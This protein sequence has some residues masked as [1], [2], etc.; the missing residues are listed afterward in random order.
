MAGMRSSRPARSVIPEP[1]ASGRGRRNGHSHANAT[2][3]SRSTSQA[4]RAEIRPAHRPLA[5]PAQELRPQALARPRSAHGLRREH[6]ARRTVRPRR[7]HPGPR[8]GRRL[9]SR[10]HGPQRAR[11]K[12]SRAHLARSRRQ[13]RGAA[14]A[15]LR[16]L[17]SLDRGA[18]RIRLRRPDIAAGKTHRDHLP[19]HARRASSRS[20]TSRPKSSRCRAPSRSRRDSVAPT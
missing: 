18:G 11:G 4:R 10:P 6:A 16:P 13:L 7:R 8:P 5:R 12:T 17:P 2:E 9:R 14:H 3:R 15:R 19:V 20:A 1:L